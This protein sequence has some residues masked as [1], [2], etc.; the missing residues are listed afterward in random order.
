MTPEDIA[1][2]E[3]IEAKVETAPAEDDLMAEADLLREVVPPERFNALPDIRMNLDEIA[4]EAARFAKHSITG[5][6]RVAVLD[7]GRVFI[8]LRWPCGIAV[9][10]L[11]HAVGVG[12][13]DIRHDG[14]RMTARMRCV[15]TG[16][17]LPEDLVVGAW[18]EA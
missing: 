8:V 16:G 15:P 6:C 11:N 18:G 4:A 5:V 17:D 14:E 3:A 12:L 7:P 13:L 1:R 9:A 10:Y 2:L